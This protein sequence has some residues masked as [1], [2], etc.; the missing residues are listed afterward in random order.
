MVADS[1]RRYLFVG[2]HD[3]NVYALDAGVDGSS[4]LIS[5]PVLSLRAIV[6]TDVDNLLDPE[7]LE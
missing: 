2:G 1:G 5:P 6:R 7:I 3:N 4:D